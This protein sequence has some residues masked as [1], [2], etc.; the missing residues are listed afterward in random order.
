MVTR[1]KG[2]NGKILVAM[3]IYILFLDY[4]HEKKLFNQKQTVMIV[5]SIDPRRCKTQN[6]ENI[7]KQSYLN[8]LQYA[9]LMNYDVIYNRRFINEDLNIT[10]RYTKIAL[11]RE[12]MIN[13]SKLEMF[14][15]RRHEW[16][17]WIDSDA[18]VNEMSFKLPFRRYKH[19]HLVAWGNE[20]SIFKTPDNFNGINSGVLLIRNSK[21][22][23]HFL[24]ELM[25]FAPN[26]GEIRIDEM[27]NVIKNFNPII[28]DQ[29]AFVYVINRNPKYMERIFFEH[30]FYLNGHFSHYFEIPNYNP[31]II[32]FA[33]CDFCFKEEKK[34]IS[35]WS[36]FYNRSTINYLNELKR[37]NQ[38]SH[39][40]NLFNKKYYNSN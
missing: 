20:E 21:W 37:L 36:I 2:K 30:A 22:S 19:A 18:L 1:F 40:L 28:R 31:F 35:S 13:E 27:R 38:E 9:Q 15:Q 26:D 14:S 39:V 17:F 10:G 29:N 25:K 12:L 16:F 3:I 5:F 34:C 8:K 24:D 7:F 23:L 33:S 32:H 4:C 6:G 11:L